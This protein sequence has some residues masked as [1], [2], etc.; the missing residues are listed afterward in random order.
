[1][2]YTASNVGILEFGVPAWHGAITYNE[3][4]DIERVQKVAL[5]IILGDKYDNYKSALELSGLETLEDRRDKLCLKFAK[6]AERNPKHMKWFKQR[7][8]TATR[9]NNPKYWN[10]I[11]RTDRLKKSP[12][13]YLTNILNEHYDSK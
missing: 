6:K 8:K 10:V 1:M 11:A 4:L 7:P 2:I 9:N 12:I 13:P 3:R 5:H